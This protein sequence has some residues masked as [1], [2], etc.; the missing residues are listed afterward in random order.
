MPTRHENIWVDLI[1]KQLE[2]GHAIWKGESK[3]SDVGIHLEC[4]KMKEGTCN[5]IIVSGGWYEVQEVSRDD[6]A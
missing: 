4:S 3:N 5:Q 1:D 6:Y 2:E